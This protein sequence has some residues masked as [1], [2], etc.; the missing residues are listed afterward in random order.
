MSVS[1]A[2]IAL[3]LSV[4]IVVLRDFAYPGIAEIQPFEFVFGYI[5]KYKASEAGVGVNDGGKLFCG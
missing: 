2:N 3:L 5:S 1:K 4:V